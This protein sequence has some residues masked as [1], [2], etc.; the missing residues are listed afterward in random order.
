MHWSMLQYRYDNSTGCFLHAQA[1][2]NRAVGGIRPYHPR[3]LSLRVFSGHMTV[4]GDT[5]CRPPTVLSFQDPSCSNSPHPVCAP[6][7]LLLVDPITILYAPRLSFWAELFHFS[8][9]VLIAPLLGGLITTAM[10][11]R[12]PFISLE[13]LSF[14]S[15]VR[16]SVSHSLAVSLSSS[17]LLSLLFPFCPYPLCLL[18]LSQ[19]YFLA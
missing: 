12:L 13:G 17:P 6:L 2:S 19:L 7:R 10:V 15:R 16:Y 18:P 4:K 3:L 5:W 1:A 11:P 8:L 9:L 14:S